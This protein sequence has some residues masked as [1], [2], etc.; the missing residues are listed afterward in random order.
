MDENALKQLAID[1]YFAYLEIL[2]QRN[3]QVS[4]LPEESLKALPVR[5]IR[6]LVDRL[7]QLARTPGS[8]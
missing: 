5:D 8:R 7:K 6:I 2:S 3:V 4:A 1:E